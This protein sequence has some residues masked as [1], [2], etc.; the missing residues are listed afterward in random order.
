MTEP[1]NPTLVIEDDDGAPQEWDKPFDSTTV[2]AASAAAAAEIKPSSSTSPSNKK[3]MTDWKLSKHENDHKSKYGPAGQPKREMIGYGANPVQPHWPKSA[4]VALNFVINYEEGS[5]SCVLHG[6]SGSENLL[7]DLGPHCQRLGMS[8][9]W[10]CDFV[11]DC[12]VRLF[13]VSSII[14]CLTDYVHVSMHIV[15]AHRG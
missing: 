9:L 5:E 14:P 6:D 10:I 8:Y 4:K 11:V 3:T 15:F 7:S 2:A 12:P 13:S 1:T